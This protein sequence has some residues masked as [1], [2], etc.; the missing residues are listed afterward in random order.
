M[1]VPP[2]S[3]VA[4]PY[5]TVTPPNYQPAWG[6]PD[7]LTKGS[8]AAS[9]LQAHYQNPYMTHPQSMSLPY[10]ALPTR[11]S[12]KVVGHQLKKRDTCAFLICLRA[13]DPPVLDNHLLP[14]LDS[15]SLLNMSRACKPLRPCRHRISQAVVYGRRRFHGLMTNISRN[16]YKCL[17]RIICHA[18]TGS[19]T[20]ASMQFQPMTHAEA[21]MFSALCRQTPS[22][23]NPLESIAFLGHQNLQPESFCLL[24]DGLGRLPHLRSLDLTGTPMDRE[25]CRALARCI[26][27]GNLKLESLILTKCRLPG[28]GVGSVMSAIRNT[29][30]I[31]DTLLHL[32]LN[33]AGEVRPEA[34]RGMYLPRLKHLNLSSYVLGSHDK[35]V[36][37]VVVALSEVI[38]KQ[39][40]PSLESLYLNWSS[41]PDVACQRLAAA[42]ALPT[43]PGLRILEVDVDCLE[44]KGGWKALCNGL[45]TGPSRTTLR[46]L[47]MCNDLP[48]ENAVR[49]VG[50]LLL[51]DGCEVLEELDLH[52]CSL[53]DGKLKLL[54][55]VVQQRKEGPVTIKKLDLSQNSLTSKSALALA[56]AWN[57]QGNETLSVWQGLEELVLE[58]NDIDNMGGVHLAR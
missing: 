12:T 14:F 42:L 6:S 44:G 46:R 30:S 23:L 20:T 1:M 56:E 10:T 28:D 25:G 15:S 11:G 9:V 13:L 7:D 34:I 50:E 4:S 27:S 53:G 16:M 37:D 8:L 31:R 21:K 32:D 43:S 22:T 29:A 3:T 45:K 36:S 18:T 5:G 17:K 58:D 19:S 39:N 52:G 35:R 33:R 40:L 47:K 54:L 48:S 51:E 2:P 41:I 26:S 55:E 38:M 24:F 49:A 57:N